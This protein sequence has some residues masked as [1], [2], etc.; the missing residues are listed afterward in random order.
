M[1]VDRL[2]IH[3]GPISSRGGISKV[4][5]LLINNPSKK[6]RTMYFDTYINS[7]IIKKILNIFKLRRMLKRDI[8]NL[9]PDILHFHITHNF[10]WW[11]KLILI[12]IALRYK[13][14]C[15]I[16]I[17]SGK[18]DIFCKKYNSIAGKILK[19]LSDNE[20]IQVVVLEKRWVESLSYF[21]NDLVCI[22]NPVKIEKIHDKNKKN[23]ENISLLLIARGDKI[24]GHEFALE[25][26][27]QINKNGFEAN[28]E[29]T[30]VKSNFNISKDLN[31][32]IH[33]WVVEDEEV[34][35]IIKRSDFVL[36]PSEYEG[37]SMSVL[38][39]MASGSIPIVSK[40]SSET[41]SVKDLVVENKNPKDWANKIIEIISKSKQ[42][43]LRKEIAEVIQRHEVSK[44]STQWS[45]QYD[46][47][48]K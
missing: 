17:H 15:I 6:Y 4:M 12:K 13:I 35:K 18:F 48:I 36:S 10:S 41:V 40:V 45:K 24:K 25:V 20:L 27:S 5:R 2:V 7:T 30:G 16:N 11:R 23:R 47:T 22:R 31:V 39:A 42:Q 14:P 43:D 32:K 1:S 34:K 19:K 9:K 38:E 29:M 3:V 37:S 33:E 28:L 46:L 21:A 8:K 44:I 26:L